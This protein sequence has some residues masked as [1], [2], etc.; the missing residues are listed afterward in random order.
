MGFGS[1]GRSTTPLSI[2]ITNRTAA[3]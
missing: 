3:R 2:I 1:T